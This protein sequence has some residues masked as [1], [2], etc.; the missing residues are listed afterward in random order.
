MH[1][2]LEPC[3]FVMT[4]HADLG[5]AAVHLINTWRGAGRLTTLGAAEFARRISTP[6]SLFYLHEGIVSAR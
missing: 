1:P 6:W 4:R 5:L 2:D 3:P